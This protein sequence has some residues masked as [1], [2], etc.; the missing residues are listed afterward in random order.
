[1]RR[2]W[3]FVC[4][5]A[6][7]QLGVELRLATMEKESPSSSGVGGSPHVTVLYTAFAILTLILAVVAVLA[8]VFRFG[9]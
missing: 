3:Q 4:G 5:R 9:H 2:R 6:E 8:M 1:M 7:I